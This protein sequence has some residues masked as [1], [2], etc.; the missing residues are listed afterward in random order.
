MDL[1]EQIAALRREGQ[2]FALAT[3]IARRA[4]VSAHL[5]DRAIVFADGRMEGFI[6]GA[7][8]REIIRRQALDA[9]ATR[10]PR[11]VSVRPDAAPVAE[12][13]AEHVTVPMTCVS[14]GAIDVFVEPFLQPRRI[15]I[16]GTTPV[17]AAVTRL[18]R[19]MEYDVVRVADSSEQRDIEAEAVS[20]GV[21]VVALDALDSLLDE[22][23]RRGLEQAA[24]VA[25]QG[26]YDEAALERI[27]KHDVPYIGL[28][29]SRRRAESVRAVLADGGVRGV[30]GIH[31]PAGLDLGARTPSEVALSILAEIVQTRPAGARAAAPAELHEA[32]APTGPGAP[33]RA[34]DPVCGMSVDIAGARHTAEVDGVAYYFCCAGCRSRFLQNPQQFQATR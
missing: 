30:E 24:I 22:G 9:L 31:N 13:S 14:E 34:V 8:S 7:C 2:S 3:V 26:H 20:L 1:F 4:P 25:S 12:Q 33:V 10:Q 18:A 16:V 17:A 11:V 32:A 27:L 5:G 29:A 28:V 15:I 23:A 6:G 21:S 19:S